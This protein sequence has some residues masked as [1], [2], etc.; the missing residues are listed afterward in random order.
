MT[1]EQKTQIQAIRER[2]NNLSEYSWKAR[3]T[4]DDWQVD[5]NQ[6]SVAVASFVCPECVIGLD[7][8]DALFI[9]HAPDDIRYLLSLLAK[10]GVIEQEGI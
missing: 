4:S 7:E 9:G 8:K 10:N 1:D 2:L 3:Q 6:R 5:G